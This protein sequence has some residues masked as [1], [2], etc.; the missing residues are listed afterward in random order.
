MAYEVIVGRSEDDKKRYGTAGCILLGKHFVKM[1]QTNS[2]SNEIWMDVTR[3]HVVFLCGKRGSGKSYTMAAMAEGII[4]QPQDIARNIG[5]LMIDTMGIF[6]T[7]KYPN[8]HDRALL[9]EWGFSPKGL[10]IN[11]LVPY[12]HYDRLLGEGIPVNGK[13]S[14]SP[15]ELEPSQW[16]NVFGLSP[17]SPVGALLE[18]AAYDMREKGSFSLQDLKEHLLTKDD[19]K[20]TILSAVNLV[21]AA[22]EWGLFY[23]DATPIKDIVSPGK[24]TV[25]DV[26]AYVTSGGS[27]NVRALVIGLVCQKLFNQRMLARRREEHQ[28]LEAELSFQPRAQNDEPVIWV[29]I[30]E[31]HEFLPNKGSTPAT[32]ALVTILR[33]GRQPG[34]SLVLATQQP[35]KIHTDVMT[36]SDIVIS[37][38]ITAKIDTD[39]L[40]M[41]TQSY[42]RGDLDVLLND[43]PRLKGS[44]VILDD[45]NEKIYSMRVRPRF[46]WH[47]GDDP[48][49]MKS[50]EN[51]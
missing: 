46:S 43:L 47:G 49:A 12:G 15:A 9:E 30:D 19:D 11:I 7:M 44:A 5:V 41:L 51:I 25:L 14:I 48:N 36:Q 20:S 34:I 23:K 39:A 50:K 16:P 29:L 17:S 8:E 31:A 27:W 22:G 1:G 42:M 40:K 32:K 28:A 10:D 33:E 26:S 4:S 3:S 13:F 24:V 18:S 6:W 35:G 38:R 45:M 21:Q 37:H 2:L